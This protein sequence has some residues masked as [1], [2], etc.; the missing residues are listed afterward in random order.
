MEYK[1]SSIRGLVPTRVSRHT[2]E[3]K[4]R[5]VDVYRVFK[6]KDKKNVGSREKKTEMD[7]IKN[8][9]KQ[10]KTNKAENQEDGQNVGG[11]CRIYS[12]TK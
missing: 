8:N 10:N 6:K 7:S 2:K 3:P 5:K 11:L 4:D 1:K 9:T 12:R